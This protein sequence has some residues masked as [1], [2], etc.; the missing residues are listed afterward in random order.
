MAWQ[1][2]IARFLDL[3]FGKL[4]LNTQH[5]CLTGVIDLIQRLDL[6]HWQ[7]CSQS[8]RLRMIL[9]ALTPGL[10]KATTVSSACS[11]SASS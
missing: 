9:L 10:L 6:A 7:L 5:E 2:Y 4:N 3:G 8:L 11:S 1:N